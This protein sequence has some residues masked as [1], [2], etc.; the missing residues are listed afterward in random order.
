MD[1]IIIQ[2][3]PLNMITLGQRENDNIKQNDNNKQTS[4]HKKYFIDS[5]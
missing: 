5:F 4:A 2:W 1:L 3:K